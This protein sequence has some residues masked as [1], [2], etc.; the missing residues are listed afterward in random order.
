MKGSVNLD[1]PDVCFYMLEYYGI[2]VNNTPEYPFE[3][4]FGRLVKY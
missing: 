1:Q 4:Y 3:F 2:D